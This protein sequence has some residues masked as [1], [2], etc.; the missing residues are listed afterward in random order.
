MGELVATAAELGLDSFTVVEVAERLRVGEST[1][2]NYVSGRDELYRAAA[3][4]VFEQLDLDVEARDWPDFVDEIAQRCFALAKRNRG[5]R[6]YL[7]FGPY[8]PS[9]LAIFESLVARVQ[10]WLP[11]AGD[12]L[13][14]VL[15]SRP[16]VATLSYVDDPVLEPVAPWLRRAT[17]A[18][19]AAAVA[20]GGLPPVPAASWRAKLRT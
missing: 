19:M 3:A 4:S 6:E 17:L 10:H 5:L 13:A 2:Y 7:L 18:G 20:D 8:E 14:Y 1:V 9:T 16:V 12:H 15:A 11:E